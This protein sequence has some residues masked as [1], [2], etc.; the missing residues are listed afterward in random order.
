VIVWALA[1]EARGRKGFRAVREG[2]V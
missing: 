2:G 1:E